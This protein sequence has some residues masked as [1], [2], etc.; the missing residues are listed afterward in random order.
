[1]RVTSGW[2]TA[3]WWGSLSSLCFW[4]V[5]LMFWYLPS[6]ATAGALAAKLFSAQTWVTLCCGLCLVALDSPRFGKFTPFKPGSTRFWA[7]A[8]MSLAL[9]A[10]FLIAPRILTRDNLLVWHTLGTTTY[11]MQWACAGIAL[12]MTLRKSELD[13]D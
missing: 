2:F 7:M 10:E 9:L 11:A 12:R 5:P 6:P 3:L 8:G 13:Q 4:I 1:M